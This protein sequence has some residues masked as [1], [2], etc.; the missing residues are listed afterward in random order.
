MLY[1]LA[2]RTGKE[3][4]GGACTVYI[5]ILL[6]CGQGM[7]VLDTLQKNLFMLFRLLTDQHNRTIQCDRSGTYIR[8]FD[9]NNDSDKGMFI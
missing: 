5:D 9:W 3:G 4:T 1:V 6:Y 8:L 7:G 2:V